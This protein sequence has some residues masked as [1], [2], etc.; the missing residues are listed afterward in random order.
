MNAI[1]KGAESLCYMS[2]RKLVKK[3]KERKNQGL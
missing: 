3:W 2:V 1:N